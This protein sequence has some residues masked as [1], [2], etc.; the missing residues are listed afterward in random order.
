MVARCVEEDADREK[1]LQEA[2]KITDNIFLIE[3][4]QKIAQVF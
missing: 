3:N 2:R 1:M 4:T